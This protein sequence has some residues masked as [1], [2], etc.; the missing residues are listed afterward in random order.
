MKIRYDPETAGEG[1]LCGLA[2]EAVVVV[3]VEGIAEL[4]VSLPRF[5]SVEFQGT[6]N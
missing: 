5:S 3:V 6:F 1:R 4:K 2:G